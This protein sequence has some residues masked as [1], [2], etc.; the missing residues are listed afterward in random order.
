MRCDD[1]V[2]YSSKKNNKSTS[3]LFAKHRWASD[4]T[5]Q[6]TGFMHVQSARSFCWSNKSNK[7]QIWH[8]QKLKEDVPLLF[9]HLSAHIKQRYPSHPLPPTP[10]TPPPPNQRL[11]L[12]R[13]QQIIEKH[14]SREKHDALP[15][16]KKAG[17]LCLYSLCISADGKWKRQGWLIHPAATHTL[18]QCV[19]SI[20]SKSIQAFM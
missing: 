12:H 7:V 4:H 18:H 10:P 9:F 6:G 16:F 2:N 17:R 13:R 14:E 5:F 3:C 1:H 15:H 8:R 20:S 19:P 11:R